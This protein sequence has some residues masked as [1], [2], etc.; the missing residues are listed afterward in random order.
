MKKTLYILFGFILL[1][2]FIQAQVTSVYTDELATYKQAKIHYENKNLELARQLFQK[3]IRSQDLLEKHHDINYVESELYLIKIAFESGQDYGENLVDEFEKKYSSHVLLN[4]AYIAQGRY[5]FKKKDYTAAI[6]TYEKIN[7]DGLNFYTE[8]EVKFNLAYSYFVKKEFEKASVLFKDLS[9]TDRK[10]Y[11]P[12]HYYYGICQFLKNDFERAINS[13]NIIQNTEQ[14]KQYVPYYLVQLYFTQGDY[15]KTIQVGEEKLKIKNVTNYY[16]INHLI[17]Q[18]YF[19]KKD[20]ANALPYLE[21]Y[22]ANTDKMRAEDFYQLGYIYQQL[23][24]CDKAI[25]AFKEISN[26]KNAM[27]QNANYYLADCYFKT[28]DKE[29]ARTAFKNASDLDYNKMIQEESLF[30]YGKL[31]AETG[32]DR[33]AIK[34][35]LSISKNSLYYLEAQNVL[36][37]VFINTKDY[38]KAQETLEK[39][40]NV[41]SQLFQAYQAV[42]YYK[43]LQEINDGNLKEAE[44]DLYKAEKVNRDINIAIKTHYWLADLLYRRGEYTKSNQ[45]IDRYFIMAKGVKLDD[46]LTTPPFGKYIQAYDYYKLKNYPVA[47]GKFLEAIQLFKK[48]KIKNVELKQKLIADS[49][50]RI[51]DAFFYNKQLDEA[52]THYDYVIDK[53]AANSAYALYQKALIAGLKNKPFEKITILEEILD[54]YKNTPVRPNTFLSLGNTYNDLKQ[55][56][57]AYDVYQTI[58]KEFPNQTKLQNEAYLK[59][60]LISYNK[61]SI[62]NAIE[63]YK[64]VINNNA[65]AESKQEALTAIEEIYINDK[66]DADGYFEY[67]KTVPGVKIDGL[68]KDSLNFTTAKVYFDQ[69]SID[70]AIESFDNYLNVYNQGYYALDAHYYRAES[71]LMKKKYSKAFKDFKYIIDQ[72][73]NSYYEPALYKAA[74]ISFNYL[75]NYSQALKYYK[76][77][78]GLVKDENKRYDVQLGAMRSAFR[79]NN[80]ANVQKYGSK[81]LNNALTTPKERSA[82]HY[83][84]GKVAEA[85]KKYDTAL[86]HLNK[87][88]NQNRNSNWAAEARYL[89]SKIYYHRNELSL[90]KKMI[91]DANVKNSAYPYW[92]AKGLILMSDIFVAKKDLFNARAAL[93]AVLENYKED[94][95]IIKE[96][97]SKLETLT[98]LEEKTSRVEKD[99]ADGTLKLDTISNSNK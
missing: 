22:E 40:D 9:L 73:F 94:K 13:F 19:L 5:Y 97:N 51:A 66:K 95:S 98:K 71:Y 53:N 10:Y 28:G 90:A 86:R 2:G 62:D 81:I 55:Y 6:S 89:I 33:E 68:Y 60:G 76:I 49:H 59:M 75:K 4:D 18:S 21:I 65:D 30:N 92:V 69:D 27:G 39:L 36:R 77:L 25:P 47:A 93:E 24:K 37:D 99:N 20:Y 41:S 35:L 7:L 32:Y 46:E 87:V 38:K 42:S 63:N 83:Y 84:I 96:V 43:A 26:Q 57:K 50:L 45:Y 72:G 85:N 82:A 48:Q 79:I 12:S 61:G 88:I 67:V 78:D 23:G 11:Y 56:E 8:D 70:K 74:I 44:E 34:S 3:Y 15:D 31:S 29:S 80:F 17:G 64:S 54:K 58:V 14:Y 16:K 91:Q 52:S 1:S